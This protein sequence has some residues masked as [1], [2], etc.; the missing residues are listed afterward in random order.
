MRQPSWAARE[1]SPAV[2]FRRSG[3][4]LTDRIR[5]DGLA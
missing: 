2:V 1:R 5:D 3:T 4:T